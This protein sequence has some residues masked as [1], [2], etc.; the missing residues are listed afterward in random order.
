MYVTG[1][2]YN[3]IQSYCFAA[4]ASFYSQMVECSDPKSVGVGRGGGPDNIFLNI[5]IFHTEGCTRRPI[6]SLG[7]PC[8][9]F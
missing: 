5:N 1:S 9:N 2:R 6:A 3:I 7:G 4:E 8:Q